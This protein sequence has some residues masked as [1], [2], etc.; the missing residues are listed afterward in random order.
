MNEVELKKQIRVLRKYL[1]EIR[2]FPDF[3]NYDC[4]LPE[5]ICPLLECRVCLATFALKKNPPKFSKIR[6]F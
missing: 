6:R 1:R 3:A 2:D 5:D 4:G